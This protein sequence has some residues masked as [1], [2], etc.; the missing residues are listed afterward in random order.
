[1]PAVFTNTDDRVVAS[2]VTASQSYLDAGAFE[3]DAIPDPVE[4][5]GKQA[6]QYYTVAGG[7]TTTYVDLPADDPR[8]LALRLSAVETEVT[9]M[10]ARTAVVPVTEPDAVKVRDAVAGNV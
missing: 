10:R 8:T 9:G 4:Q 2:A 6:I 7:F 3:V 5:E 1:M